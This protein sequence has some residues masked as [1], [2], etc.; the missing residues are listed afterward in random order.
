MFEAMDIEAKTCRPSH[1]I[2]GVDF[3][4]FLLLGKSPHHRQQNMEIGR[5]SCRER[6]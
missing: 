6:V 4:R 1:V 3:G 5:A 2:V